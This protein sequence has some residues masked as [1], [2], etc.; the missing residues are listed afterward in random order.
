VLWWKPSRG[1]AVVSLHQGSKI[2]MPFSPCFPQHCSSSLHMNMI[3]LN[4]GV[5][6]TIAELMEDKDEWLMSEV[7]E[8]VVEISMTNPG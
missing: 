1:S 3:H 6:S 5:S 7:A 8:C 2:K 4:A